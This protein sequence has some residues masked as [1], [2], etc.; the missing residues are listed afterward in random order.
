MKKLHNLL[1]LL[2]LCLPLLFVS[3]CKK[4]LDETPQPTLGDVPEEIVLCLIY[5]V[6]AGSAVIKADN[7]FNKA[8]EMGF[9][10]S[11]TSDNPSINDFKA[12]LKPAKKVFTEM[13]KCLEAGTTYTVR[14]CAIQKDKPHYSNMMVFKTLKKNIEIQPER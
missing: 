3:A 14:A 10:W 7:R 13:I 6:T 2:I 4:N 9:C 12:T 8:T 1:Y 11:K 5:D